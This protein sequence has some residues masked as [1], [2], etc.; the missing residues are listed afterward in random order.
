MTM[1]IRHDPIRASFHARTEH[2][3]ARLDYQRIGDRT[4]DLR[5]TYVPDQDRGQGIAGSLVKRALEYASQNDLRI[6]PTCPFVRTWLA[7]NPRFRHL[8]IEG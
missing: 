6:I 1:D 4:L 3:E 5:H 7:E 8:V 2:G